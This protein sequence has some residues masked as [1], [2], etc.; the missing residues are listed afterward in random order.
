[1]E[2]IERFNE[3]ENY[4]EG[5]P[6]GENYGKGEITFNEFT[7]YF[8]EIL[9]Q[10]NWRVR[11]DKEMDYKDGNQLD[12]AILAKMAEI[13]MPPAVEPL[14]GLTIESIMGAEAKK[15]TDWRVIP[16]HDKQGQDIADA[17][18]QKLNHAERHSKADRSCSEAYEGQVSVGVG[19][20]EVSKEPDPF[21]YPY[22][23]NS[24]YRNEIYWDWLSRCPMLSDARYLI[25]TKWIDKDIAGLMFPKHK[26]L[27]HHSINGWDN[28]D[29]YSIDGGHST[30]LAIAADQERGWS[31]E[32]Q[33]WRN[34]EQRR[35]RLFEVWYRR[36]ENVLVLKMPDGRVV[37]LDESNEIH[38]LAIVNGVQPEQALVSKVRIAWF[39]GPHK[40]SDE[41]TPHSHNHFP[42]VPFWGHKE[43]RTRVPFGRIRAMMYMQENINASMSKIRWGL[44][45]TVTIRT[46]G[47]YQ[48]EDDQ[49]R[50]EVAR[51]DADIVLDADEM[52]KPGAMFK[53][54]RNFELNEQQYKMLNDAR[55]S[56]QKLG[57]VNENFQ[58]GSGGAESGV[59]FNSAVEQS[60]Q[61]L[62][63]IDDNFKESRSQVGELLLSMITQDLMG[64]QEDILID[65]RSLK[66]DRMIKLNDPVVE[67]GIE[68]L[69]NDISKMLLKVTLDEVPTTSSFRAQQLSALSEAYKS[70]PPDYQRIMMPYMMALT[71]TPNKDD[72]IEAI[73]ASD[74]QQSPDAMEQE[75]KIRELEIKQMIADAQI[76]KLSA[77]KVKTLVDAQFAALQAGAQA[78]Q[79]SEVTP[80]ADA[81]LENAGYQDP[82]PYGVDPN[83]S[84]LD[85]KQAQRQVESQQ[86]E[87]TPNTSPQLPPVPQSSMR[88]VETSRN[89]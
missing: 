60:Q 17:L 26:D 61:M 10:P 41:E 19:W 16:D 40:L 21:K 30:G 24:V 89:E 8:N 70:S 44:A 15:R 85:I 68:Y 22:R 83:L 36:W 72:I 86:Q 39:A 67:D 37:E 49:L 5:Q 77:E 63:D 34:I 52:A 57:G 51:P 53:I 45:A 35:I 18:N 27:L 62:A 55:A 47:A 75:N 69:S 65:G 29:A 42:Y 54:E 14:I 50:T 1:M 33:E 73:K 66:P 82:N 4:I 23:C 25:R 20:V 76:D 64:K 3:D 78:V 56:I 87:V 6:E 59:L 80:V 7:S 48:G 2:N 84:D 28:F 31:I 79:L 81:V 12:S 43:D 32:E 58:D 88:G 46:E 71:D 38:M 74:E 9:N 13:G 11:A